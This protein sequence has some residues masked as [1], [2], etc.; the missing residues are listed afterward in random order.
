MK[1][2]FHPAAI[3]ELNEA[4]NYYEQLRQGS[5]QNLQKKFTQPFSELYNILKPGHE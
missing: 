5:V 2:F 1:Y 4:V 3:A